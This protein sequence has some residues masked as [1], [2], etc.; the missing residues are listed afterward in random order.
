MFSKLTPSPVMIVYANLPLLAPY[1]AMQQDFEC[2]ALQWSDHFNKMNYEGSWTVVPLRSVEGNDSIIPGLTA[3]DVFLDHPNV[4]LFPSVKKLLAA[5]ECN[6]RSVRLLNLAAGASI[7]PH[8][9]HELSFEQ[10]E[11]RLHIPLVTNDEVEFYVHDQRVVMQT[12]ECWYMNANLKHHVVNRGKTDR[13]HL[14]IDCKVNEWLEELMAS[15]TVISHAADYSKEQLSGMIC[16]LRDQHT[17]TANQL[18]DEFQRQYDLY[19]IDE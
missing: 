11:A 10:G 16:A 6:L 3:T 19:S 1:A 17:V 18:A 15:A 7:K 9:D 5:M 8:R 2:A 4:E 12:G 13:V 14:V